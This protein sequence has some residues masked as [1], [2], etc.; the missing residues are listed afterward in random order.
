MLISLNASIILRRG[1]K[2]RSLPL[3][4]Y[5]LDYGKQDRAPGEFVEQIVVPR[6][7][8]TDL[9]AAYKISKRRDE[10]ISSVAVGIRVRIHAKTI[11]QASIAF[12]GMA[13]TPKR[14]SAAE[15][16]LVGQIWGRECFEAAARKLADDFAPLTD[17]RASSDYRMLVAQNLLRRFFLENDAETTAPIQLAVA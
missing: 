6:A 3:Q 17:W 16:A 12:G 2:R 13:A 15:A 7:K 14:A 9:N 8:S 4:D 11:E 10:D 5:F 1:D